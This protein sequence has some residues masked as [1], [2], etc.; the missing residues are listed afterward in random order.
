MNGHGGRNFQH[1]SLSPLSE[2]LVPIDLQDKSPTRK[3]QLLGCI[4][5]LLKLG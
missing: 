2:L 4:H 1:G 5:Q 3:E